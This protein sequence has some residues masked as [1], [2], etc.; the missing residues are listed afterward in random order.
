[1]QVVL[2]RS[3]AGYLYG[4]G[5]HVDM[6]AMIRNRITGRSTVA[7]TCVNILPVPVTPN[8]HVDSENI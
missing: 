1:M 7:H 3:E 6:M 8:V 2:Q 4:V 5:E